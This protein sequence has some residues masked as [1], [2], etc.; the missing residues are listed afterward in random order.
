MG[1]NL[2]DYNNNGS[3]NISRRR[4]YADMPLSFSIHPNTKDLTVLTDIDAVKQ[5]VKN[6]VMT[7]FTER[8]F[9]PN[10]GSNITGLLF[11]PANQ[12][13][14]MALKDEVIRVLKEHEPRVGGVIVDILDNSDRN[15]YQ[16]TIQFNVVFSDQRQETNF[17]LERTR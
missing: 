15:A 16:I 3:S 1:N 9:E 17:Y 14:E 8:L 2:S 4:L 13:T 5:S 12:F 10:M 7:N 11:E 6:L